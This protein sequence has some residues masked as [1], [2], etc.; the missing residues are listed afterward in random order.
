[1]TSLPSSLAG[2]RV[3]LEHAIAREITD[4]RHRQRKLLRRGAGAGLI[5]A[6][7]VT[8]V[9]VLG[10]H[11][12][13]LV[14]RAAAALAF[15]GDSVM[16]VVIIGHQDN[17]DGTTATWRSESWQATAPPY[18]RR[19]IERIGNDPAVE[20]ASTNRGATSFAYDPATNTVYQHDESAQAAPADGKLR[21]WRDTNGGVHR[22]V[23]PAKRSKATPE[24]PPSA[25]EEPFRQ[26]VLALLRSG[27]AK[28]A[29]SATIG[30]HAAIRI[31]GAD[32]HATYLVDAQTYDPLEFRTV[33]DGGGTT[34]RFV[35]YEQLPLTGATSKLLS[36]QA[37]HTGARTTAD[38][39]QWRAAQSRLFP[40]G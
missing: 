34:L 11:A 17:G 1:M 12:P 25:V 35:T 21:R 37:Q 5:A 23:V 14:E 7:A 10:S 18:R 3:E 33:G 4:A 15:D 6:A 30:G 20:T 28:E 9:A 8:V 19:Q 39:D 13:P 29:G 31:V 40:H 24:S 32:G 16:H 27:T 26:E 36:I 2:F 38:P 22:V